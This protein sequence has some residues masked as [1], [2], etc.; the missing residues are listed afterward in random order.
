MARALGAQAR[1][2]VVPHAGHGVL[3]LPCMRDV[4]WRFIDAADAAQALRVDA[5]CAREM[6]VAFLGFLEQGF[7]VFDFYLGMYDARRLFAEAARLGADPDEVFE[8]L[9]QVAER[10][11]VRL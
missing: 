5:G 7:R 11:G 8:V 9:Q 10:M 2:E 4:A 1:H 3:A 6:N